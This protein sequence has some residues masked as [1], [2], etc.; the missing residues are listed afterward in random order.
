MPAAQFN[1]VPIQE[2][3]NIDP[4]ALVDDIERTPMLFSSSVNFAYQNGGPLTRW[5]LDKIEHEFDVHKDH[6]RLSHIVIDTKVVMLME[7]Q[8]PAIPGWHCDN[9]KRC[10]K[11]AQPDPNSIETEGWHW[12]CTVSTHEDGVSNT[13]FIPSKLGLIYES[14][15]VWG[16][17]NEHLNLLEGLDVLNVQKTRDGVIY[18]FNQSHLHRATRAHNSGWRWFFR[19]SMMHNPPMNKIRNQVQVYA[20]VD[21]GW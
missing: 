11:Y 6:E 13:N 8:Y 2:V 14:D 19:A 4:V 17:I 12:F 21:K 18:K 20:D 1:N 9:V 5:V 3:G 15:R 7:G 16:S 10:S